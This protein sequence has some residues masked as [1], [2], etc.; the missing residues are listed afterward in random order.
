MLALAASVFVLMAPRPP[1]SRTALLS[2]R[3]SP[4]LRSG[5]SGSARSAFHVR[6]GRSQICRSPGRFGAALP[7][8]AVILSNQHSGSLRYYANRITMRFEW[9]EPDVYPSALDYLEQLGARSMSFWTTGSETSSGPAIRRSGPV[10]ARPSAASAGR[11][12]RVLLRRSV[13]RSRSA[14]L[15][16]PA[17]SIEP[18]AKARNT[19]GYNEKTL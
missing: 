2:P 15:T 19:L 8:N 7:D 16:H 9:L 17:G 14:P 18:L 3:W 11:P 4:R 5:V 10:L 12:T 6:A 1:R 13:H